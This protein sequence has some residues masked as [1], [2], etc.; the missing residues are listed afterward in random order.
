MTIVSLDG[1]E[2][3]VRARAWLLAYS[4]NTRDAYAWDLA[5]WERFAGNVGVH[6]FDATPALPGRLSEVDAG[7]GWGV[8]GHGSPPPECHLGILRACHRRR[9]GGPTRWPGCVGPRPTRSRPARDWPGMKLRALLAAAEGA[10]LDAEALIS[11]LAFTGVR[12]SEA[13]GLEARDLGAEQG[14]RVAHIVRKGGRRATVPLPPP[15]A[16]TLARLAAQRPVGPLF[17]LDRHQAA[18]LIGRLAREAGIEQPLTPHGLRHTFVG[19]SLDAGAT[20]RQVQA[21]G[22]PSGPEDHRRL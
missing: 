22:R 1:R 11:L 19:L 14:H 18:R 5:D 13:L 16:T 7:G 12:I 17:P 10:D 3:E 6:I 15:V 4:G 21:G 8:T 20:I 9:G 2:V